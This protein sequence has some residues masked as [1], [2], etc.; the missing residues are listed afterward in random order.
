VYLKF[1]LIHLTGSSGFIGKSIRNI[2][3]IQGYRVI[4]YDFHPA[5]VIT[6]KPEE[7]F[8]N[9]KAYESRSQVVLHFGA[10]ASTSSKHS[11]LISTRNIDYTS[12]LASF[13]SGRR[14]PVV[15][16][17]SAAVYGSDM[18][19]IS[20]VNP[21]GQYGKSKLA[22]EDSLTSSFKNTLSDLVVLRL[23]NVYGSDEVKKAEMM[24]IPSR[25]II[26]GITRRKVQIW[27]S[28]EITGQ[29]RDFIYVRDIAEIVL[30]ILEQ[31]PWNEVLMDVGT[32]DPWSFE[33]V[34][35]LVSAKNSSLI[36]HVNFPHLINPA[37]YQV[38]TRANT[39]NLE[40]VIGKFVFSR[41]DYNFDSIWDFY[42]Q[43]SKE[44]TF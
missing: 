22:G 13:C 19:L 7:L 16:A 8:E 11:H 6:H 23:F 27:N 2:L 30:R 34:A 43:H 10:V 18:R 42:S 37:N 21:Q 5:S 14:I 25:F 35:S 3:D 28:K 41:L 38:F 26:D 1:D 33:K 4:G 12:K 24:S 36:E 31:H 15:F 17:S 39:T 32:G 20:E 9:L 40:K 44:L 29:S